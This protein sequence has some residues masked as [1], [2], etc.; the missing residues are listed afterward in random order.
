MSTETEMQVQNGHQ[1]RGF[2]SYKLHLDYENNN[3]GTG[4]IFYLKR[5]FGNT[6]LRVSRQEIL[7]IRNKHV[8][9]KSC[10]NVPYRS[11]LRIRIRD[12]LFI[13]L[14]LT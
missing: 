14:Y 12:W 13:P 4:M 3:G 2:S 9:H 5:M 7:Y 11:V 6:K 10:Q 1:F 8:S